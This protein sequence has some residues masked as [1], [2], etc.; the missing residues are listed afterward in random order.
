MSEA[1]A[2]LGSIQLRWLMILAMGLALAAAGTI[3]WY[4]PISLTSP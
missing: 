2:F 1:P 4:G 3:G